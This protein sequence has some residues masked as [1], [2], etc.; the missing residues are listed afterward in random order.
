MTFRQRASHHYQRALE[1]DSMV[2]QHPAF[3]YSVIPPSPVGPGSWMA[4]PSFRRSSLCLGD[5]SPIRVRSLRHLLLPRPLNPYY[6]DGEQDSDG[7]RTPDKTPSR[8]LSAVK[9][10]KQGVVMV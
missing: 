9:E 5:D 2:A 8:R 6:V 7:I 1:A 4:G 3:R 10:Y